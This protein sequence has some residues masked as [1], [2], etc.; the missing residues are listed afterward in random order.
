MVNLYTTTTILHFIAFSCKLA[1]LFLNLSRVN[2]FKWESK[3]EMSCGSCSQKSSSWKCRIT[4][5]TQTFFQTTFSSSEGSRTP[6]EPYTLRKPYLIFFYVFHKKEKKMQS[7]W[8]VC[9]WEPRRALKPVYFTYFMPNLSTLEEQLVQSS[10]TTTTSLNLIYKACPRNWRRLFEAGRREKGKFYKY[11]NNYTLNEQS[12]RSNLVCRRLYF[13][14]KYTTLRFWE[15]FCNI[16]NSNIVVLF[17][18]Y[19]KEFSL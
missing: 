11:A 19:F 10:T 2:N 17:F 5:F 16:R 12:T 4:R 9:K 3:N 6:H 18:Q 7:T 15:L 8:F 13:I 1:V 14:R